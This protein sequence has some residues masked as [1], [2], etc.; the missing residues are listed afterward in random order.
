VRTGTVLFSD[1]YGTLIDLSGLG[2][3]EATSLYGAVLDVQYLV[4]SM[5][6]DGVAYSTDMDEDADTLEAAGVPIQWQYAIKHGVI[7]DLHSMTTIPIRQ[8]EKIADAEAQYQAAVM[9]A[10]SKVL[11]NFQ[12]KPAQQ[13]KGGYF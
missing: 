6:I 2:T 5:R 4:G 12:R 11:A 1:L 8:P 10:K 13:A 3:V 7:A 9:K